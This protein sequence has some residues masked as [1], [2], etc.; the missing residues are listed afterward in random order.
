LET[1][2]SLQE[3]LLAL[4]RQYSNG[5]RE[6]FA[7]THQL[8]SCITG[9]VQFGAIDPRHKMKRERLPVVVIIGINYTQ[10][11]LVYRELSHYLGN[12]NNPIVTATDLG[13]VTP[14]ALV[15]AAYNRNPRNWEAPEQ[16][17]YDDCEILP[18]AA[19]NATRRSRLRNTD[20]RLLKDKFH[21]IVAN[22]CPFITKLM[23]QDQ[24]SV[25]PDG[26][27]VLLKDW[28]SDNYLDGLHHELG[29]SVDLW[30]G[31]AAKAGTRWVWPRFMDFVQRRQINEWLLTP[32][33]SGLASANFNGNYRKRTA[34]NKL[35]ALFGPERA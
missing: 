25:T 10:K 19:P 30:I 5:L 32:N 6:R 23:W 15:L 13:C 2:D 7:C 4:E 16:Q 12:F 34:R 20:G 27:T 31:H 24:V 33:I 26:C 28:S 21:L 22:F 11:N 17:L 18:Y 35:F 3:K 8:E 9:Q 29:E 14:T 1:F